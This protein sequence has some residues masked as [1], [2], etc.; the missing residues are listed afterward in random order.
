MFMIN[1]SFSCKL[2]SSWEVTHLSLTDKENLNWKSLTI[3]QLTAP[4]ICVA[5]QYM[6]ESGSFFLLCHGQGNNWRGQLRPWTQNTMHYAGG[7]VVS[8]SSR[9]IYQWRMVGVSSYSLKYLCLNY[10]TTMY[11]YTEFLR[12]RLFD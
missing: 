2:Q 9:D 5:G 4:G 1:F 7:W 11:I 3:S 10:H 6:P 8:G 12:N